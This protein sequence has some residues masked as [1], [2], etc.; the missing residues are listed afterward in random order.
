[1]LGHSNV[2]RLRR[3][4]KEEAAPNLIVVRHTPFARNGGGDWESSAEATVGGWVLGLVGRRTI[5]C[6]TCMITAS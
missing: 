1:M 5:G 4:T 3:A 2:R 6:M